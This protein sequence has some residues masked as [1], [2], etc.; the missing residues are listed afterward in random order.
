MKVSA[1][2]MPYVPRGWIILFL[3]V[4]SWNLVSLAIYLLDTMDMLMPL[5]FAMPVTLLL[6]WLTGHIRAVA[7]RMIHPP[8]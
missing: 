2:A 8:A 1:A 6:R 3:A 7:H 5:A 4:I